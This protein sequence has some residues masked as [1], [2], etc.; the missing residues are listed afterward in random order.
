MVEQPTVE[1]AYRILE[2]LKPTYEKHHDIKIEDDALKTA[3]DLSVKYITDRYL[4]DKAI[5]LVDEAASFVR[6]RTGYMP[7][8]LRSLDRE[9]KDLMPR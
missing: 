1:E 8:K 6:L 4:P 5:D 3:V 7:E 9:L 2:G